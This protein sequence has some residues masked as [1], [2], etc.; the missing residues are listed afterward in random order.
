MSAKS[1]FSYIT[2]GFL[3]AFIVLPSSK[4]V[5]NYYYVLIAIPALI[6]FARNF[7]ILKPSGLLEYIW[8]IFIGYALVFGLINDFG[9]AK[10]ALYILVFVSVIS[11]LVTSE[12]YEADITAR[13]MFWSILLYVYLSVI[14][15]AITGNY[16]FGDRVVILPQRLTGPIF[17]SILICCSLVLITPVWLRRRAIVEVLIGFLLAGFCIVFILQSRTG[18]VGLLLW[19]LVVWGWIIYKNRTKSHALVLLVALPIISGVVIL[20]FGEEP[21]TKLLQ[22][23]DS[24]RFELWQYFLSGWLNCGLLGGCGLDFEMTRPV[25]NQMILHEHNIFLALG[26]NLGLLPLLLF[27]IIML[28]ALFHAYKQQNWWGS[29]L[30]MALVLC[31]FDGNLVIESPNELWLLIWLPFG[32]IINKASMQEKQYRLVST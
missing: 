6:Y 2:F 3:A 29:F 26:V 28:L 15:L 14:W 19:A 7:K 25:G 9:F 17:T 32:L 20:L 12:F 24:G 30:A 31:N 13:A 27:S 21:L 22:R 23:A 18:I 11:K 1:Y 10:Y 16:Q 4:L 8:I 5:N